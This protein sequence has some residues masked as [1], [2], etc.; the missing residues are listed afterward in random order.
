M[1][2]TRFSSL[3]VVEEKIQPET[4]QKEL[5]VANEDIFKRLIDE[6]YFAA[7]E[8]REQPLRRTSSDKGRKNIAVNCENGILNNS[9][10]EKRRNFSNE[11]R[12]GSLTKV[13]V[14]STSALGTS[15]NSDDKCTVNE[16]QIKKTG[17][18]TNKKG[19]PIQ[20]LTTTEMLS[21][22]HLEPL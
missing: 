14:H 22:K 10:L 4:V 9:V 3:T 21:F 16:K 1:S 11:E 13:E 15:Y 5:E 18:S 19:S 12:R 2:V 17:K 6:Q 7:A 20:E 8:H